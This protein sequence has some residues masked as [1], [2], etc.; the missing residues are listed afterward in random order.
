MPLR[1]WFATGRKGKRVRPR[2]RD[3]RMDVLE[4]VEIL[5]LLVVT[6]WLYGVCL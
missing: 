2:V 4:W 1:M 6:V 3:D 5:L